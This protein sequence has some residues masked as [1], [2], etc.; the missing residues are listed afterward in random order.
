MAKAFEMPFPSINKRS[1]LP[2]ELIHI[3]LWGP[4]PVVSKSAFIIVLA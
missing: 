2:F 3:D 1:A 4:S